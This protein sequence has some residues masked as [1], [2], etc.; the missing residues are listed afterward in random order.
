MQCNSQYHLKPEVCIQEA[1]LACMSRS[2]CG[3]QAIT[4]EADR[5]CVGSSLYVTADNA[6]LSTCNASHFFGLKAC[7]WVVLGVGYEHSFDDRGLHD[8]DCWLT[9]ELMVHNDSPVLM[10]QLVRSTTYHSELSKPPSLP[11]S[12]IATGVHMFAPS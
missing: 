12:P 3:Q 4:C 11:S 7:L 6:C 5:A 10:Q 1:T 8:K 9:K 2:R